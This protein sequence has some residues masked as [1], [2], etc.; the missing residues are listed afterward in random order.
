MARPAKAL[1]AL[2]LAMGERLA[3]YKT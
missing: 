3:G 2:A 1:Q